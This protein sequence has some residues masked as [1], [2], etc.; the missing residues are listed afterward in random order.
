MD[1]E[2]VIYHLIH[3]DNED[4]S[5][6]DLEIDYYDDDV[7]ERLLTSL[8]RNRTLTKIRVARVESATSF[9][10]TRE[11]TE[12]EDLFQAMRLIPHLQQVELVG[13]V[14]TDLFYGFG[15]LLDNHSTIERVRIDLASG[16]LPRPVV[17]ALA[18]VKNLRQVHL[19]LPSSGNLDSLSESLTLEELTVETFGQI[20][21][22]DG[23]FLPLAHNNT[24]LKVL[25]LEFWS[26]TRCYKK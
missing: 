9:G 14:S 24:G 4:F 1:I 2:W 11:L 13:F 16:V 10:R 23:H 26:G 22:E 15:D 20:D 12:I 25:D 7:W 21:L 3:N 5:S 17:V 6:V 8:S 18:S 19:E